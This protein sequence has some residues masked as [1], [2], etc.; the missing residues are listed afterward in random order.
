MPKTANKREML[1]DS[2]GKLFHQAGFNQTS[3]ADIAG[4]SGVPLGNVYYYFKTKDDLAAAVIDRRLEHFNARM[5]EWDAISDPKERLDR[6]LGIFLKHKN[7]TRQYGCPVGSL[8]QE[9]DKDK[10]ALS[11]KADALLK[12]QLKWV[13]QQ[14]RALGLKDAEKSGIQFIAAMQGAAVVASALNDGKTIEWEAARL[15]AWIESL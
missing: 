11:R 14:F 4:D 1:I 12:R 13:T 9:L 10:T 2:A 5:K 3:L 7:K 6:F 15:K 8:C